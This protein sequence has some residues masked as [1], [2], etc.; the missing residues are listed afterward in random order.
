[1]LID[2][3]GVG[4]VTNLCRVRRDWMNIGIASHSL[5][6]EVRKYTGN[7][8][9]H[10]NF[11]TF[12]GNPINLTPQETTKPDEIDFTGIQTNSSFYGR[13]FFRSG[14]VG[15]QILHIE[16]II[17]LMTSLLNSRIVEIIYL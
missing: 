10:E 14:V 13:V 12:V 4:T 1:M 11:M 5:G 17:F 15:T 2:D 16:K 7:Y 9:V 3:V 6:S 8:N